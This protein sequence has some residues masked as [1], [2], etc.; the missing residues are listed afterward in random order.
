M[1]FVYVSNAAMKCASVSSRHATAN[2]RVNW[3]HQSWSAPQELAWMQA[4][5][6]EVSVAK[7]ETK[8]T[9]VWPQVTTSAGHCFRALHDGLSKLNPSSFLIL[10]PRP[11]S[12]SSTSMDCSALGNQTAWLRSVQQQSR[13]DAHIRKGILLDTHEASRARTA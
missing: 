9:P 7:N 10:M 1:D 11:E 5:A 13:S 12:G 3:C 2:L 4:P 6:E 8:H